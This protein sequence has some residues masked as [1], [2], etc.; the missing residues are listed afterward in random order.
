M[1]MRYRPHP[2]SS[3]RPVLSRTGRRRP[4]CLFL[5]LFVVF[6]LA[7][8]SLPALDVYAAQAQTAASASAD[9]DDTVPPNPAPDWSAFGGQAS[10]W[11]GYSVATAGDVNGDGY[12]DAI[13]G[14]Y[15]FDGSQVDAGR[16]SVYHGSA[17]GL[18]ATPAWTADGDQAGDGFGFSVATAGD[19][20]GD[21]YADVIIGACNCDNG[22]FDDGRA[23]VYF[24]SPSGLGHS[25]AWTAQSS[26]TN[27]RFGASVA[28]AGDVNGD[29]YSDIVV[30]AHEQGVGPGHAYLF[31]GSPG[32]PSSAPSWTGS[33]GQDGSRY[34]LVVASAGD[35]NGDG[36]ADLAVGADR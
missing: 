18:G 31:L 8:S 6:S 2:Y 3:I 30:G 32:G 21:G 34:G 36:Y 5:V 33:N 4:F 1:P 35:V 17:S 26:Q 7:A 22:R 14:A 11:L 9:S 28:T 13:V 10:A 27:A 12:T 24:G 25:P 23:F 16:V 15:L 20:N 29:G 19:V